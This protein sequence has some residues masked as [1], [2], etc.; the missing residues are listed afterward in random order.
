MFSQEYLKKTKIYVVRLK[1][2]EYRV[3]L[4]KNQNKTCFG[5]IK[6]YKIGGKKHK[7]WSKKVLHGI[8]Y[9]RRNHN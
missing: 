3:A 7:N 8:V 9:G 5:V 1:Y 4:K 2:S 6:D